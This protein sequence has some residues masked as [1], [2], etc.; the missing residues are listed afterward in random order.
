MVGGKRTCCF[1]IHLNI[2]ADR[3]SQHR[4]TT[5]RA[6][7]YSDEWWWTIELSKCSTQFRNRLFFCFK[8]NRLFSFLCQKRKKERNNFSFIIITTLFSFNWKK[9]KFKSFLFRP[10][11]GYYMGEMWWCDG[12]LSLWDLWQSQSKFSYGPLFSVLE[13]LAVLSNN[14][15]A[16]LVCPIVFLFSLLRDTRHTRRCGPFP[17]RPLLFHPHFVKIKFE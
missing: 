4:K 16:V 13:R 7:Y 14:Y 17:C 6:V 1:D 3:D 5:W 8:L 2:R 15:D 9:E 11:V 12:F 10:A